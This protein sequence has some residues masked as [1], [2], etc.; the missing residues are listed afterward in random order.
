[1]DKFDESEITAILEVARIALKNKQMFEYIADELDLS[2]DY[3]E[4]L[5]ARIDA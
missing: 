1:M 2:D 4:S 5:L 3:L